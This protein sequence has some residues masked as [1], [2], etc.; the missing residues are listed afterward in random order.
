MYKI[1]IILSFNEPQKLV[2]KEVNKTEVSPKNN[3]GGLLQN[4]L[5]TM[6]SGTK[7]FQHFLSSSSLSQILEGI[8]VSLV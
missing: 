5:S 3:K 2:Q 6:K 4:Y 1:K 8:K 7:V